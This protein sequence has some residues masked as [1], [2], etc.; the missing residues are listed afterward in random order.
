MDSII[1]VKLGRVLGELAH[2]DDNGRCAIE[3][4]VTGALVGLPGVDKVADALLEELA[5]DLD[6]GHGDGWDRDSAVVMTGRSSGRLRV[7]EDGRLLWRGSRSD[8]RR[9][10]RAMG[11]S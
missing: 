11:K 7:V 4:G 10:K 9:R 1:L 6:V 2:E 8:A 5:V 3:D